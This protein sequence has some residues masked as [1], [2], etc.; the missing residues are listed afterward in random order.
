MYLSLLSPGER[1][2]DHPARGSLFPQPWLLDGPQR[3]RMDDI[4]GHGWRL[5][6]APGQAASASAATLPW[7]RTVALGKP[8]ALETDGVAEAWFQRHRCVAALVRPDHY[9]HGVAGTG[10]ETT[11]LVAELATQLGMAEACAA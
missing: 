4:A 3:R 11:A 5:V 1:D 2:A 7:L 10:E 6:L 8:G 9:V